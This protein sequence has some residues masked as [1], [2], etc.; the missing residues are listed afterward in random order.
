MGKTAMALAI[1]DHCAVYGIPVGILSLEMPQRQ[2]AARLVAS[3]TGLP[4]QNILLRR[5]LSPD[6][7]RLCADARDTLSQLPLWIE[8]E[9][10]DVDGILSRVRRMVRRH[11]VRLVIIDQLS[12]V[13]I[14]A[15]SLTEALTRVSQ[16]MKAAAKAVDI[17]LIVLHQLNRESTKRDDKRPRMEDLRQSGALEQDADVILMIHR[18]EYYLRREEPHPHSPEWADWNADMSRVQGVADILVEKQRNGPTGLARTNFIAQTATF[19]D[20]VR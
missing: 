11:G 4:I 1:A 9:S 2:L 15:P 12:Q 13:A 5:G 14:T 7:Q 17:P 6:D 18:D 20:E 3:R 16:T 19:R 8:D 10:V